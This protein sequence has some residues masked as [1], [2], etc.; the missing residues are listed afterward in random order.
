MFHSA[1]SPPAPPSGPSDAG[2]DHDPTPSP[3]IGCWQPAHHRTIQGSTADND[4]QLAVAMGGVRLLVLGIAEDN[5]PD[6]AAEASTAE[7]WRVGD[8]A[9][10]AAAALI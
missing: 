8:A 5:D 10:S 2:A 9:P 4:A 1:P 3:S 6:V 7:S